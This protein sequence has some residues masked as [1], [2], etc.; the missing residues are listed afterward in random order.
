MNH[1]IAYTKERKKRKSNRIDDMKQ[2]KNGVLPVPSERSS[3]CKGLD[4]SLVC[5]ACFCWDCCL[6]WAN[7]VSNSSLWLNNQS[8]ARS[9]FH[10]LIQWK[11]KYQSECELEREEKSLI[12]DIFKERNEIPFVSMQVVPVQM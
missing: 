12:V 1:F 2:V 3:A 10:S 8:T 6:S 11:N 9:V 4:C 5:G 7:K